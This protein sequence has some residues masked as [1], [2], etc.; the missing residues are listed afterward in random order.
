M[1]FVTLATA[2]WTLT[3]I[4]IAIRQSLDYKTTFRA[5][6]VVLI[7]IVVQAVILLFLT[8]VIS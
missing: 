1:L 3:A 6:G 2:I 8:I 7:S 5:I 4:I